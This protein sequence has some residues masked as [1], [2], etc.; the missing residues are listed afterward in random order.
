[1]IVRTNTSKLQ[2]AQLSVKLPR[3]D[4]EKIQEMPEFAF[5]FPLRVKYE[6]S[7]FVMAPSDFCY[8]TLWHLK[9]AG[10]IAVP[11]L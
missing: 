3:K 8:N 6:E 11:V 2:V 10:A 1:M 7:S 5:K 4:K 9:N